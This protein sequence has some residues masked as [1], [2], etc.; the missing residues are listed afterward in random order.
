MTLVAGI[1][2]IL[3]TACLALRGYRRGAAAVLR[4][5]LPRFSALAG[6]YLTA[7]LA[8]RATGSV[9]ATCLLAGA[10]AVSVFGVA[11]FAL[12]R[13]RRRDGE[14]P[15]PDDD[16]QAPGV[17]PSLVSRLA[18]CAL[19]VL[20]AE[21]FCFGLACLGSTV[22]FG[23]SASRV[24]EPG[25]DSTAPPPEWVESLGDV[26]RTVADIS[27][28]GLLRRLPLLKEYGREV[29]PLIRIL[30]APPEKL[31]RVAE[32]RNLMRFIDTPAVRAALLDAEYCA[33]LKRARRGE[34]SAVRSLLG[35][36]VTRELVSCPEIREFA[37]TV[38][39]SQLLEDMGEGDVPFAPATIIADR[40][41]SA[42]D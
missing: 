29:L 10:V 9:T 7:W 16:P 19:G 18:G 36:P 24:R 14:G 8:W 22:V 21:V 12:R 39:P 11:A 2:V 6:L 34:L 31:A 4:G 26:C 20:H 35:S 17:R 42:G 1:L 27:D 15:S 38:T 5:W 3:V 40:R 23:V 25:I 33:L 13:S 37:K 28:V 30:S 32:K 41:L